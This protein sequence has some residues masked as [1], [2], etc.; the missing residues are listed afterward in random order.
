MPTKPKRFQPP[1]KTIK[2]EQRKRYDQQRGTRQERGY[3]DEWYKVT[4]PR[5]LLRDLYQC[6]QCGRFVGMKKRDAH[7]DHIKAKAEGGSDEDSNLQTLC[8]SCHSR[9]TVRQDGG[10]GRKR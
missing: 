7:V 1:G 3:D 2:A 6:Q 8:E 4:R 5:I 10:Y 9:K